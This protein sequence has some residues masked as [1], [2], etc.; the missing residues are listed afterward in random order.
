MLSTMSR[1]S[2]PRCAAVLDNARDDGLRVYRCQSCAGHAIN[3]SQIRARMPE[4]GFRAM[5]QAARAARPDGPSCPVCRAEMRV[6]WAGTSDPVEIDVCVGCQMLW[7]DAGEQSKLGGVAADRVATA[8]EQPAA[9][10]PASVLL[11][12]SSIIGNVE[13]YRAQPHSERGTSW[14]AELLDVLLWWR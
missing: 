12:R 7:L 3:L 13:R 14:L 8:T 6:I 11:A 10:R 5:W 2:C 4:D 9:Q 1:F